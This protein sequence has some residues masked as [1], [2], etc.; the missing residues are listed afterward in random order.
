ML[1]V[2]VLDPAEVRKFLGIG[3]ENE[4]E[5]EDIDKPP[6]PGKKEYKDSVNTYILIWQWNR[7]I[8]LRQILLMW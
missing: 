7:F 1:Y 6:K 8:K 2:F 4:T 5:I 3:H